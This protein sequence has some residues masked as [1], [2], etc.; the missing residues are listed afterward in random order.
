MAAT[1]RLIFE[2]LAKDNASAALIKTGESAKRASG[3]VKSLDDRLIELSRRSVQARLLTLSARNI[4]P[5]V[6]LKGALQVS[7]QIAALEGELD[8]LGSKSEDVTAAV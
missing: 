5:E 6:N 8:K 3:D 2:I 4:D 7:A 1:E